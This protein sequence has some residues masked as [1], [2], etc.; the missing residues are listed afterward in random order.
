L[1]EWTALFA[2]V[3][4]YVAFA[5]IYAL[6]AIGLNIQ[7]GYG[8]MFNAGIAGFW[9]IGAYTAAILTTPPAP[10]NPFGY[11]GHLGGYG[12][13]FPR[14]FGFPTSILA[15]MGAAMFITALAALL[16]AIPTLR[17]RADYLAIATL[18][19]ARI[20]TIFINNLQSLTGGVFGIDRIPR[21]FEFGTG[22][23]YLTEASYAAFV[24][25]ILI[26]VL[27]LVERMSRSP[28]GRVMRAVREDEDA[29]VALG[30]NTF[31]LK[32]QSFVIGASLMG[33]A[34]ALFAY[35]A[36]TITVQNEFTP[37]DTFTIW[38][39]VVVGGSGNHKGAALGAFVFYFL[40]WFTIRARAWFGLS[41]VFAEKI[42]FL[43][44]VAIG[45][46]LIL[47]VLLRPSGLLPEPRRVSRRPRIVLGREG[48][49]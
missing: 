9:A 1:V 14:L 13:L 34:G 20:I 4:F 35:F 45:V 42:F 36:R 8:G 41:A 37:A 48:S 23:N 28:W 5:S 27:F 43:Q 6:L 38:T 15:G 18:G 21:P 22:L 16:I 25:S 7:W 46:I 40:F 2:D 32:L 39:M 47:L 12:H 10:P 49:A 17:L 44:L 29:A 30:K 31:L 19:L 26:L 11:P 3:S 24:G 33:L